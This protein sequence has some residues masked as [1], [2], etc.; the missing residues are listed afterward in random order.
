[1]CRQSEV[2][3]SISTKGKSSSEDACDQGFYH[4]REG[5]IEI[6]INLITIG[7]VASGFSNALTTEAHFLQM[8]LGVWRRNP[9]IGV[10]PLSTIAT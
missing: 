4:V 6:E 10:L 5:E 7:P 3:P 2:M 1:M 9:L 8:Q